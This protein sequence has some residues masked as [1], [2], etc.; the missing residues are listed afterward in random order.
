MESKEYAWKWVTAD[1]CLTKKP[2]ELLFAELVPNAA[3]TST[4]RLYNGVNTSGVTIVRFRGNG[5]YHT[6][7]RPPQPVYCNRGLYVDVISNVRG[8]FVMWRVLGD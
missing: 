8:I 4:S 1:E 2:C 3:G 6:P 5:G 7:F